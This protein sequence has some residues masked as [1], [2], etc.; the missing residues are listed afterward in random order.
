MHVKPQLQMEK[1]STDDISEVLLLAPSLSLLN[2]S[3]G[4]QIIIYDINIHILK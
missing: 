4:N 1:L 3:E 2:L